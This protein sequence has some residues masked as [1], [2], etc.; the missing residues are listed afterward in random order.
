[1]FEKSQ[2]NLTLLVEITLI[3]KLVNYILIRYNDIEVKG[4]I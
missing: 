2:Y 1:M 4:F 3:G